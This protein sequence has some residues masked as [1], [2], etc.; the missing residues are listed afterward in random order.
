[1]KKI[2]KF[3]LLISGICLLCACSNNKNTENKINVDSNGFLTKE[4]IKIF[5]KKIIM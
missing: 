5:K 4:S 2:S 3:L 1:M